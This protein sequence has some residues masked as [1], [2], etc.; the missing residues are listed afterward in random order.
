VVQT[1]DAAGAAAVSDALA[2]L[3]PVVTDDKELVA[4]ADYK[5][6]KSWWLKKEKLADM[7]YTPAWSADGAR[8]LLGSSTEVVQ[9]TLARA[10][11][12]TPGIDQTEDF[13]RLLQLIPPL[14]RGGILYIN[15]PEAATWGYTV[16][17]PLLAL[18]MP[19]E[20]RP[21]FAALPQDA[22][23]LFAGLTGTLLSITGT[24]DGVQAVS[25]GSVPAAAFHYGRPT[26]FYSA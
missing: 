2:K 5:G 18:E 1:V 9:R 26:D 8:V 15:T 6:H 17:L 4:S 12:K 24:D 14:A 20:L 22:K 21:R 11:T 10:E 7:P 13:K 19:E 16:G 25:A 23:G 3:L